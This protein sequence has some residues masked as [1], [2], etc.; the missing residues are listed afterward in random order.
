MSMYPTAIAHPDL[1]VSRLPLLYSVPLC[2]AVFCEPMTGLR[3]SEAGIFGMRVTA[4]SK[5]SNASNESGAVNATGAS[6]RNQRIQGNQP[7]ILK[8]IK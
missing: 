6:Q 8:Q 3:N 7:S 4:H 5:T 1:I 2:G